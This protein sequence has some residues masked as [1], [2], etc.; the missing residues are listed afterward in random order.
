MRDRGASPRGD[1]DDEFSRPRQGALGLELVGGAAVPGLPLPG[2]R[3]RDRRAQQPVRGH[4]RPARAGA[5]RGRA[6][7]ADAHPG[8]RPPRAGAAGGP[9]ARRGDGQEP[10]RL[11]PDVPEATPRRRSATSSTPASWSRCGSR[12]GSARRTCT[13]TPVVPRRVAR[14][15]AAQPLRPGGLAARAHRAP[16]RLPLP[17]RDLHA[18]RRS[19]S[20]ATTCCRSCSATRSSAGSTSRPTAPPGGCWSRGRTPSRTP[21]DT[22]D[23]LGVELRRMA[24]W[25]GLDDVVVEP[26]GDLAPALRP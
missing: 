2:R 4:L 16:L 11:L 21:P 20:T 5:A 10:Q 22:A 12:A 3:G 18:R 23:E 15:G 19:G 7:R 9:L 26:R 17:H 24:D 25:L 1:L 6:G 14:A 8:G 13:S